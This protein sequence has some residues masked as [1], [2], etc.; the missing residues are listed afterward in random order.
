MSRT[1]HNATAVFEPYEPHPIAQMLPEMDA[2]QLEG[3]V[4]SIRQ[5]G[6]THAM[7]VYEDKLLDGRGRDKA[8]A[9]AGIPPRYVE[10][11]GSPDD[12][13]A[14]VIIENVHRRHLTDDQRR[15]IAAK[16]VNTGVGSNQYTRDDGP[17]AMSVGRAS[18]LLNVKVRTVGRYLSIAKEHKDV[19]DAVARGKIDFRMAQK[20][21]QLPDDDRTQV[22]SLDGGHRMLD[23]EATKRLKVHLLSRPVVTP[24]G[25]FDFIVAD[26]PW[27]IKPEPCY[28]T[29]SLDEIKHNLGS[30]LAAMAADDCGLFLWATQATRAFAEQMLRDIGWTIRELLVWH[31]S[32]G[33]CHPGR[34]FQNAEFVIL[35]EKGSPQFIDT[36]GFQT[37]FDGDVGKHS[38]KPTEF[39]EMVKRATAGRR[40]ELFARVQH[41]GF[42]AHGNEIDWSER[43]EPSS[44]IKPAGLPLRRIGQSEDRSR[45]YPARRGLAARSNEANGFGG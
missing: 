5:N 26:A 13:L 37:C 42:E 24:E 30:L 33:R 31:K 15:M 27:P 38:E 41:D 35:A 2:A 43:P 12:A 34:P 29:M 32:S 40:L 17:E 3:L 44:A 23:R 18:S 10:F 16:L 39:F 25:R 1:Y 8:C 36:R 7:V 22:L 6:L 14:F 9:C 20:I 21:A 19:A 28:P 11:I 45:S 4:E